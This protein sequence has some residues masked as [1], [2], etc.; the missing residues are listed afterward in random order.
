MSVDAIILN[1][2][3]INVVRES[4]RRLKKEKDINIIVVDNG[5]D[6]ESKEVLRGTE[7]ITLV[8]LHENKGPSVGRNAGLDHSSAEYVFLL[9]GDILY[10][11]GT[12]QGLL[13]IME[14]EDYTGC[15]GVHNPRR[16]DG[17]QQRDEAHIRWPQAPGTPYKDFDMAWTQYGL[18]RGDLLRKLR[19]YDQGVFGEAGIGY[20]DD[21]LWHAMKQ[22][23]YDSYYVPDVLYYHERHGGARFLEARGLPVRSD[24]RYEI[25]KKHWNSKAW[26]EKVIHQDWE[27]DQKALTGRR[28]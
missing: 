23:G 20:E 1:L 7:G 9:D 8:D 11:P 4:I 2:N 15:I 21:W 25:F 27:N 5:S 6:D 22:A 26:N 24:E 17:T 13:D 10:I 16:Y 28:Q 12:I 18:F 3:E 14:D 19:F